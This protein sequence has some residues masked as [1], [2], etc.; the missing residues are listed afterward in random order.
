MSNNKRFD[1]DKII[2]YDVD[3]YGVL[4]LEKGCLPAGNTK[5][6]REAI[7]N[8]LEIA[9]RK[10]ARKAHPDIPGGSEEKFKL[11]IR[12]QTI[13]LDP[14]LR[15]IYDSGGLDRPK[16]IGDENE[17][18]VNWDT[19]GTYRQ[20]TQD[21]TVGHSLFL[22]LCERG[23]ELNLIPSFSPKYPEHNY[24]WD[25]TLDSN[26]T[27][28]S[29]SLVR[30]E[31]EVLRLTSKS[32][33][34]SNLLPFKIYFCIPRIA[35]NFV[36]GENEEFKHKDGTVDV[37]K[38]MLRFAQYSDYNL[39]ETTSLDEAYK[40]I[41]PGGK[42]E[43]DLISFRDGSMIKSKKMEDKA[44]QQMKWEKTSTVKN[45]DTEMIKAILTAKSIKCN[46]APEGVDN[47]IDD[48]PDD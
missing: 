8:I 13:L 26:G 41:A 7:S 3:Y 33:T 4:G 12:A 21:D 10:C 35:L 5:K 9:Y 36:R 28:L 19:I 22:K 37:L 20:G 2:D 34:E 23:K 31:D 43:T 24:E 38:G 48:I 32:I 46:P 42:L 27:K 18:E 1:P 14:I 6:E 16:F 44:N 40:Y 15:R 11:V 25:W 47:F 30:D 17:F 45:L 39:L 29:L